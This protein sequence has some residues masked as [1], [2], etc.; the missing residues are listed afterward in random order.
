MS[1]MLHGVM[2]TIDSGVSI[3]NIGTINNFG[4]IN[5]NDGRDINNNL[6]DISNNNGTIS[7]SCTGILIGTIPSGNAVVQESCELFCNDMTIDELIASEQYNVIDNRDDSLGNIVEGTL[8]DD[9]I[10]SSD[11]GDPIL[12]WAGH[13][14]IIGEAGNDVINGEI[15]H[16]MIF[17]QDG[18][19]ILRGQLGSDVLDGG[20]GED[21]MNGGIGRTLVFLMGKIQHLQ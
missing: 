3:T 10:L 15:G 6:G 8:S 5:N 12:G 1:L 2:L 7:N 18:N 11:S 17:G 20:E 21:I 14:C 9:L 16:D 13:D 19:D 4:S